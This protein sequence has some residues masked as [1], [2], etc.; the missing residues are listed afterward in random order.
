[1]VSGLFSGDRVYDTHLVTDLPLDTIFVSSTTWEMD[2]L[3]ARVGGNS[4]YR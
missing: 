1:M 4:E 3:W 2:F